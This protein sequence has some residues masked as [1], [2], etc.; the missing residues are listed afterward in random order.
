MESSCPI[1]SDFC[2]SVEL[3]ESLVTGSGRIQ[4]KVFTGISQLLDS[5]FHIPR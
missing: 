1:R 5:C 4:W 2:R 3:V